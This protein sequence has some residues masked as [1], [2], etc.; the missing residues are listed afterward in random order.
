M[1][2]LKAIPGDTL[3]IAYCAGCGARIPEGGSYCLVCGTKAGQT[4]APEPEPES[5]PVEIKVKNAL[6]KIKPLESLTVESGPSP[7][8]SVASDK[9]TMSGAA[10]LIVFILLIGIGIIGAWRLLPYILP[11]DTPPVAEG[12]AYV[13][14]DGSLMLS[15]P[16]RDIHKVTDTYERPSFTGEDEA[17]K[18]SADGRYI[19]YMNAEGHTEGAGLYL[20]DLSRLDRPEIQP[21][22]GIPVS[23]SAVRD[24]AFSQRGNYMVFLSAKG[25]LYAYDYKD[26]WLLD[27]DVLGITEAGERQV[28]YT[29]KSI[30]VTGFPIDRFDLYM[31]SFDRE[32]DDKVL[33]AQNA[34]ELLDWTKNYTSFVFAQ[35][36]YSGYSS[37]FTVDV[38]HYDAKLYQTQTLVSA[39]DSVL[40]VSAESVSVIYAKK[41]A[42]TPSYD[43][44]ITDPHLQEDK[45]IS[46]PVP[47]LF[48]LPENYKEIF[49]QAS[50]P[51]DRELETEREDMFYEAYQSYQKALETFN[52]KTERD[53][54]R[55]RARQLVS[56]LT[57]MGIQQYEI[58]VYKDHVSRV[59]D[60]NILLMPAQNN[61]E[62]LQ[63]LTR[64]DLSAG[65]AAYVRS[66]P[67]EIPKMGLTVFSEEIPDID[68][69]AYYSSNLPRQLCFST[70]SQESRAVYSGAGKDSMLDFE[71]TGLNGGIYFSIAQQ[72]QR[73]RGGTLYFAPTVNGVPREA[74]VVDQNVAE[75]AP[76]AQLFNGQILYI[77]N[78]EDSAGDLVGVKDGITPRLIAEDISL[79]PPFEAKNAGKS[80]L[81]YRRYDAS[82][83]ARGQIRG[84]LYLLVKQERLIVGD[85]FSH[86]YRSDKL[87]YLIRDRNT[88]GIGEIY[89]YRE[90]GLSPVDTGVRYVLSFINH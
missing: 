58:S 89:T 54:M 9:G 59:I 28:L 35:P 51:V 70:L 26:L 55:A 18:A 52:E 36:K 80:M 78:V 66:S 1:T 34:S 4:P 25:G 56:S 50:T 47:S 14:E 69:E 23:D 8:S 68:I 48:G 62:T 24:F 82:A 46:E 10:W 42:F 21:P 37:S 87:I 60:G 17:V 65:F 2:N 79:T 81:Y 33:V 7:S 57:R 61:P 76:P 29:K 77:R 43:D 27:T 19:A 39:A 75:I 85:V 44:L 16:D 38:L 11:T 67:G 41:K 6:S 40:D 20:L 3:N 71:V 74:F 31:R 22:E 72:N 86:D 83:S 90:G 84:E 13:K 49:E 15:F 73:Q 30:H 53:A 45:L 64:T 88:S 12:V 63:T 5:E 32:T